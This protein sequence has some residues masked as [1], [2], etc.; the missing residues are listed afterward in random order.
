MIPA[1]TPITTDAQVSTK[2]Q[3]AV[4]A[5]NPAN[6]PFNMVVISDFP[7]TIHDISSAL[8]E[9]A[10]AARAVFKATKPKNPSSTH[11]VL[12]ALNTNQPTQ[13]IRTPTVVYT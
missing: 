9:P 13:R 2:A 7:N 1:I 4:I 10:A 11:S 8:T 3:D 6:V 5:T 12:P